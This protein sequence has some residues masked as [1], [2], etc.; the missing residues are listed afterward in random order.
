MTVIHSPSF[1]IFFISINNC[2]VTS[3]F[4]TQKL[5]PR[6]FSLDGFDCIYILI[7]R[8]QEIMMCVISVR[9]Y[10]IL[11]IWGSKAFPSSATNPSVNLHVSFITEGSVI[12]IRHQQDSNSQLKS[13]YYT[14]T[15]MT[16][17]FC[18]DMILFTCT[19]T[20]TNNFCFN[21]TCK[22]WLA[23]GLWFSPGTLFPPP[24]KLTT[25]IYLKYCWKWR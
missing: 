20:L 15:T 4:Q 23:T 25:T 12:N 24:I 1:K 5:V 14:I 2:C 6:R 7:Y 19:W 22:Q 17:L 3:L 11:A 13:Y 9:F 10:L 18:F 21:M 8:N 16:A